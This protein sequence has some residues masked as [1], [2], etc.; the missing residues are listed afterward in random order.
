MPNRLSQIITDM[1]CLGR[2]QR[3][4]FVLIDFEMQK[5]LVFPLDNIDNTC[6]KYNF[7]SVS[8][9]EIQTERS[10]YDTTIQIITQDRN[11]YNLAFQK[12]MRS[13]ERG[14][15]YLINL[16]IAVEIS[17][18]VTLDELFNVA[19]A[20]YRIYM[21]DDFL[22]FSP[23]TFVKIENGMISTFPMKGTIDA[24]ITDAASVLI[25][26]KKELA[27]H[28]TIVDLMRN[29]L[30]IVAKEVHVNRFRYIDHL[31]TNNKHLLQTS[32]EICGRLPED[33]KSVLGDIIFAMLPA[34]S[35]SGAPKK[36]TC[37]I[38][39]EAEGQNRGYYTGIAG[40]FDGQS[41]DSCVLIRYIEYS[42]GKTFYRAGGGITTQSIA[43]SE[44]Q[45]LMDKVYV[46]FV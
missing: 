28:Y 23:E 45:E 4:F 32:S 22:V 20:K 46:P 39:R 8:N 37:E 27:E 24:G 7:G 14:D 1:N 38:I 29:D 35:I 6:L 16:T 15:S 25:A 2:E 40:I 42:D 41:F 12:V 43:D 31:L 18:N 19:G 13:L 34:G 9:T 5:P 3:P 30:S 10:T 36:R 44:Y 11:N 21:K 33:W 26:D 17:L